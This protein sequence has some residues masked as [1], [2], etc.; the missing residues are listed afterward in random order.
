MAGEAILHE[1]TAYDL[2]KRAVISAR[3]R[4]DRKGHPHSRW[5]AVSDCFALGSTYSRDLC[6]LFDL[7]PDEMVKR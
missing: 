4:R 2:L 7:D 6:T 5:T 3:S 1:L